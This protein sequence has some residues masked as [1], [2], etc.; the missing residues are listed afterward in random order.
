M[1]LRKLA[2]LVCGHV[3]KSLGDLLRGNVGVEINSGRNISLSVLGGD[4]DD[5]VR[6]ACTINGSSGTILENINLFDV[7][8]RD[9]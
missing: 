6:A 4:D 8:R 5:T 9:L 7:I 1:S 3:V 2:V